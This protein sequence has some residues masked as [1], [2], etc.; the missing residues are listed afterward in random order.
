MRAREDI[1][2]ELEQRDL[3]ELFTRICRLLHVTIDEAL[4]DS[5][6]PSICRARFMFWRELHDELGFSKR[7]IAM[8]FG[9][10]RSSILYGIRRAQDLPTIRS[11]NL[12]RAVLD[13]EPPRHASG[14]DIQ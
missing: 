4:T 9:I 10:D 14:G 13:S 6:D 12:A 11:L 8:L 1:V 2:L 3:L 7:R 5:H